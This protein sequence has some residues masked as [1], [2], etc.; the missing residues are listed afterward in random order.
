MSNNTRLNEDLENDVE[1]NAPFTPQELSYSKYSD[2]IKKQGYQ[3]ATKQREQEMEKLR[4]LKKRVENF[5]KA[6][7]SKYR[8]LSFTS[9][10]KKA[11]KYVAHHKLSKEEIDYFFKYIFSTD[12]PSFVNYSKLANVLGYGELEHAQSKLEFPPDKLPIIRTIMDAYALNAGLYN[13]VVTQSISYTDSDTTALSGVLPKEIRADGRL[14]VGVTPVLAAMFFPKIHL[15]ENVIIRSNLGRI[16]NAK[17]RGETV[18]TAEDFQ[19]YVNLITDP[20]DNTCNE[21]V[22]TDLYNRVNLQSGIWEAVLYLRQGRYYSSD[23]AT[24]T[25]YL[26][27]CGVSYNDAADLF[28]IQDAGQIMRKIL[29]AFSIRPTAVS[30]VD[31]GIEPMT[32]LPYGYNSAYA[33]LGYADLATTA[34][35]I[36][37]VTLRLSSTGN[38]CFNTSYGLNDPFG[39]ITSTA[40]MRRPM[41]SL[42]LTDAF[43]RTQYFIEG[44]RLV[45]KKMELLYSSGV[46]IFHINRQAHTID[47]AKISG[48]SN[49]CFRN[50]PSFAT[51]SGNLNSTP[52]DFDEEITIC[53]ETFRL[54]SVVCAQVAPNTDVII[55]SSAII[56]ALPDVSK[57]FDETTTIHYNPIKAGRVIRTGSTG[58]LVTEVVQPVTFIHRGPN[59]YSNENAYTLASRTGIIFIYENRST[60]ACTRI[61]PIAF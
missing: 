28:S 49:I 50:L 7:L 47:V 23:V 19:L 5:R 32:M 59:P 43:N 3:E 2:N 25:A 8:E 51:L 55:G 15:F 37:M 21:N 38:V 24:F 9:L 56:Y 22:I 58:S 40:D 17:Y 13:Q 18:K 6:M 54:R 35:T 26:D 4:R 10:V 45:P 20:V 34:T 61:E 60:Y 27:Q 11:R 53:R 29:G 57:G 30:L 48:I 36:P 46:L 33:H 31:Y 44:K 52:V 1:K 41:P 39:R 14:L 16:V 42:K 12:N